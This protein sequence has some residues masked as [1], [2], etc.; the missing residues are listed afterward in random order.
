MH[1]DAIK[2]N[3]MASPLV[4]GLVSKPDQPT[5]RAAGTI[6]NF[7]TCRI[8]NVDKPWAEF[9]KHKRCPNGYNTVCKSCRKPL[10]KANYA[11]WTPEYRLINAARSRAKR[12]GREFALTISD[13]Q[14]PTHCPVLG[15]KLQTVYGLGHRPSDSAPSIDRIDS[16]KGY[17]PENITVM[18]WRANMLKNNMTVEEARLVLAYLERH[19]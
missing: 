17:T 9:H 14:I 3:G 18:S 4:H 7:R 11:T 10:S 5:P 13:I 12:D 19:V 8:C 6:A 15:M 2:L 1:P 16:S